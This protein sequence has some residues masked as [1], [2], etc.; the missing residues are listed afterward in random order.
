MSR[1]WV[2]VLDTTAA[3]LVAATAGWALV[4]PVAEQ[5]GIAGSE[6]QLRLVLTSR[7]LAATLGVVLAVAVAGA[8]ARRGSRAGAYLVAVSGLTVLG[9]GALVN[10]HV[11]QL[12]SGIALIYLAGIGSGL[13][14]GG[15][16]AVAAGTR[17]PTVAL[18]AGAFAAFML[19]YPAA[20]P[21]VESSSFGWTAYSLPISEAAMFTDPPWWLLLPSLG[22]CV[23]GAVLARGSATEPAGSS[24]NPLCAVAIVVVAGLTSNAV[25]GEHR[26]DWSVAAPMLALLLVAIVIAAFL[27]DGRDGVFLLTATA[28]LAASAPLLVATGP[29]PIWIAILLTLLLAGAAVGSRWAKPTLGLVLLA[30]NAAAGLAGLNDAWAVE[31]IR[32]LA[33]A[34]IAG[35]AL[36]SA[37]P[38]RAASIPVGLSVLFVPSALTIAGQGTGNWHWDTLS[39]F[40][41]LPR[42]VFEPTP[43]DPFALSL[44]MTLVILACAEAAHRLRQRDQS[45]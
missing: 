3:F 22:C 25:L 19:A 39:V 16:A 41:D 13:A 2:A 33:L 43:P 29:D 15:A 18:G 23:A 4:A 6:S 1:R 11:H 31:G 37:V 14:M 42:G 34:P 10:V 36:A 44:A 12:E 27:L 8:M 35:Y 40:D 21:T 32:Y 20:H 26:S 9:L 38:R 28:V 30:V 7:P 45:S 17:Y 5:S 24:R